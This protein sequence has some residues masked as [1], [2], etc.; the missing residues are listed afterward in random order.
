[1]GRGIDDQTEG[2]GMDYQK[3]GRKMLIQ[4]VEV[5]IDGQTGWR[6]KEGKSGIS[7]RE[8]RQK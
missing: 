7:D 1:M 2:K 5:Q 8:W 4:K 3:E 6:L